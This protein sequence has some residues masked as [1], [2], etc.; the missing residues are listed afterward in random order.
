MFKGVKEGWDTDF[1]QELNNNNLVYL[2]TDNC[3]KLRRFPGPYCMFFLT[4]EMQKMEYSTQPVQSVYFQKNYNFGE[5]FA[6]YLMKNPKKKT[7]G[8]LFMIS[9][10]AHIYNLRDGEKTY[11]DTNSQF[12]IFFYNKKHNFKL[13]K[14]YWSNDNESKFLFE[15]NG[16]GNEFHLNGEVYLTHQGRTFRPWMIDNKN[17]IWLSQIKA[18]FSEE[19]SK[20][21][22]QNILE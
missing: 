8:G 16:Q 12:N 7:C 2:G 6:K 5:K 3:D 18:W 22:F 21:L 10:N 1:I 14:C 17:R 4:H 13:L 15:H 20:L 9:E 19:K 11:L